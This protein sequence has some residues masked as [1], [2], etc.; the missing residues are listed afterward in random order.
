MTETLLRVEGMTCANCVRHVGDALRAVAGVTA[1]EVD[2][3]RGRATVRHDTAVAPI[4]ALVRAVHD[5]GYSAVP[6]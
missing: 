1:V 6:A 2:L 4:A 5:E 3:A